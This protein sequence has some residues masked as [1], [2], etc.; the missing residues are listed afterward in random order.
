M[1][2]HHMP[3]WPWWVFYPQLQT[4]RIV[5][6]MEYC[7]GGSLY[8]MLDQAQYQYGLPEKQFLLVLFHV[9][10]WTLKNDISFFFSFSFLIFL[11]LSLSFL[12]PSERNKHL[13]LASLFI[14]CAFLLGFSGFCSNLALVLWCH[15]TDTGMPFVSI[16]QS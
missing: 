9:G 14:S 1:W 6:V 10:K 5:L 8:H 16:F 7:E 12:N 3:W 4:K 2:C 11:S 13:K 15:A